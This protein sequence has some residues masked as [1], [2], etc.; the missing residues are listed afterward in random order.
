MGWLFT[1]GQTKEKLIERLTALWGN[2]LPD[3]G[4]IEG[5]CI[6]QAVRGNVLYTVREVTRTGCPEAGTHRFIGIDLLRSQKDYGWGN[7]AEAE[8]VGPYRADD[9]PLRFF[10]LVPEPPND[11]AR[12]WRKRVIAKAEAR[13]KRTK[14]KKVVKIGDTVRL[15][16]G[17]NI[18][19]VR[20]IDV[21]PKLIGIYQGMRY[22]VATRHIKEIISA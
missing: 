10:A 2:D 4:H 14:I 11:Y 17:C 9:C 6:A 13:A 20:V 12:E 19:E 1:Q 22:R 5:K 18:P 7:K 21:T 15:I 3:G 16:E 8:S